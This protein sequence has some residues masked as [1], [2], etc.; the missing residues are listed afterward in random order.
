VDRAFWVE[1][2]LQINQPLPLPPISFN[3]GREGPALLGQGDQ[4]AQQRVI[5]FF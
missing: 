4:P 5:L 3:L 1:Q 2:M